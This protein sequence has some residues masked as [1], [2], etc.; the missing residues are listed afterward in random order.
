MSASFVP[1]GPKESQE[2]DGGGSQLERVLHVWAG[3]D[4]GV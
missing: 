2:E 3:A 1:K 4:P